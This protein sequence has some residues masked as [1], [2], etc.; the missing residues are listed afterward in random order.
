VTKDQLYEVVRGYLDQDS[1]TLSDTVLDALTQA[2]EGYLNR[3]LKEHN[4]MQRRTAYTVAAGGTMIPLPWQMIQLRT[5]KLNGTVYRQLPVFQEEEAALEQNQ[6]CCIVMGDCV[7][8]YPSQENA[9]AYTLDMAVALTSLTEELAD[10][11]WVATLY[12]DVYQVGL[13]A[14]AAGYLRDPENERAWRQDFASRVDIMKIEG[15]SESWTELRAT[16]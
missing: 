12:P 1:T 11:N 3:E 4:R 10:P 8:L 6:P 15:W 9:A 14:E 13:R 2:V 7:W 5:V 16:R